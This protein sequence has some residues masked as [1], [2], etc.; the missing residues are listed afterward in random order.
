MRVLICGNC[1]WR[2]EPEEAAIYDLVERYKAECETQGVSLCVIS[3]MAP[4]ADEIAWHAADNS[5]VYCDEFPWNKWGKRKAEYNSFPTPAHNMR[6]QWMLDSGVDV[7]H[8]FAYEYDRPS[9]TRDMVLRCLNKGGIP[10]FWH[11]LDTTYK[12]LGFTGEYKTI[13]F[14][15][16]EV[17][18]QTA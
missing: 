8:A 13:E 9:G 1:A 18:W 17:E 7:C 10:V 5:D 15:L 3:G 12:V 14:E 11:T 4:G 16:E 6:N 2:G